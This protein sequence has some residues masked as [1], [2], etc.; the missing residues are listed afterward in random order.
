MITIGK[1]SVN[2][3]QIVVKKFI[4]EKERK[5]ARK[6]L[7]AVTPRNDDPMAML[8]DENFEEILGIVLG[9]TR[10]EMEPYG[11]MELL[12]AFREALPIRIGDMSMEEIEVAQKK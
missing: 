11:I 3:R 5:L 1:G 9:L 12:N 10:D 7:V 6:V 2:E 4:G 8:E